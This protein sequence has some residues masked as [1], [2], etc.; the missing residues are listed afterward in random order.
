MLFVFIMFIKA[1][2]HPDKMIVPGIQEKMALGYSTYRRLQL[3]T[4]VYT[5]FGLGEWLAF[6]AKSSIQIIYN[7]SSC[8][9][10]SRMQISRRCAI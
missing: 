9:K 7:M 10:Y 2:Y 3:F 6:K 5:C 4:Q 8:E 1:T